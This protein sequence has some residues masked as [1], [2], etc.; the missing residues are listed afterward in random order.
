MGS[1]NVPEGT[2]TVGVDR[3]PATIGVDFAEVVT[4]GMDRAVA[5]DQSSVSVSPPLAIVYVSPAT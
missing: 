5:T 3:A 2:V 4:V 1:S